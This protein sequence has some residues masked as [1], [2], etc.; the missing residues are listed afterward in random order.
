MKNCNMPCSERT[1][2][3]KAVEM[4]R[5][6][7][8]LDFSAKE[9]QHV[10][11]NLQDFSEFQMTNSMITRSGPNAAEEYDSWANLTPKKSGS[12]TCRKNN[13]KIDLEST[14]KA[15]GDKWWCRYADMAIHGEVLNTC[16]IL[17]SCS[18]ADALQNSSFR[19]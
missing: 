1:H 6:L 15:N 17:R 11:W 7:S 4:K 8:R 14:A 9:R 19:Q 12:V 2:F 10:W 13:A 3:A 16:L 18:N 5:I